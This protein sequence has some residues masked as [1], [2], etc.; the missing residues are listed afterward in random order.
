MM[1]S[2]RR[3][4][5]AAVI[6]VIGM[7]TEAAQAGII[8]VY[9]F[10]FDALDFNLESYPAA[11]FMARSPSLLNFG[12]LTTDVVPPGF[13]NGFSV[14]GVY[15]AGTGIGETLSYASTA[16]GHGGVGEVVDFFFQAPGAAAGVGTYATDSAGRGINTGDGVV[17]YVYATGR[18]TISAEESTAV[19]EPSTFIMG[20]TLLGIFGLYGRRHLVKS[21]IGAHSE[22]GQ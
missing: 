1:A 2:M 6:L 22:S 21:A 17:F 9:D 7:A 12:E 15:V 20:L 3:L 19:P 11:E 14:P 18:L 16:F 5:L 4:G 10:K 8:Y 13:L